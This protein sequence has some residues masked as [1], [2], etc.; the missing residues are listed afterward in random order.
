MHQSWHVNAL[1][2]P[3]S[4]LSCLLV[5]LRGSLPRASAK[6]R[7]LNEL[8]LGVVRP[9]G[10]LIPVFILCK[11]PWTR[12]SPPTFSFCCCA[13]YSHRGSLPRASA[14]YR[15]LNELALGVVRPGG[16]LMT[17]SCSGAMTQ[18]GGLNKVVQEAATAA[19]RQVWSA[20]S[21]ALGFA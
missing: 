11:L 2:L 21:I 9:G 13:A 20:P 3:H 19:E 10:V 14:K 12:E 16:V 5:H 18:S 1:R 17:C 8:A 4:M 6:Y 7:R 15:R